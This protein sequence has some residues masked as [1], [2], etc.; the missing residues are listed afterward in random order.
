[1]KKIKATLLLL[2]VVLAVSVT[3]CT[4]NKKQENNAGPYN[5]SPEADSTNNNNS[6]DSVHLNK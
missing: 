5:H 2:G 4:N 6:A 1:M 3:S